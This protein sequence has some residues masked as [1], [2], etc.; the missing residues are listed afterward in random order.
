MTMVLAICAVVLAASIAARWWAESSEARHLELAGLLLRST[1]GDETPGGLSPHE[2]KLL[3]ERTRMVSSAVRLYRFLAFAGLAAPGW[4]LADAAARG[5]AGG[6]AP[7]GVAEA[8]AAIVLFLVLVA[9]GA[10]A[11]RRGRR[12]SRA[13]AEEPPSWLVREEAGVPGA[14]VA[15]WLVWDRMLRSVDA[16]LGPLG[17]VRPSAQLV[18][19]EDSLR[20]A[21]DPARRPE[22]PEADGGEAAPESEE[23]TAEDMV[24]A[25]QRLDRTLVR[26]IMRPVNQVTA[27]RLRDYTPRRFLALCART[28]Y[29]RIPCYE[30]HLLNLTGYINVFD[31]LH[32]DKPPKDLR[33]VV[34][35]ALYVPE[36][37]RVDAVLQ[38]MIAKRQQVA[39]VFDEF[40]GTSGWLSR[41]DILEEI[42]G[43]VE[44]E[45]ERSRQKLVP[46]RGG[47]LADP[48]I[49]LD[50]LEDELELELPRRHAD[51]L[52]G[53]IYYRLGR[54]PKR[55]EAIEEQG[56][57]IRVAAI[58]KHRIRRVRLIPPPEPS[59]GSSA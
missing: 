6:A 39:I 25:I 55:G 28:G 33:S 20:L 36:V 35:K 34:S 53:F 26:E 17:V 41:E 54:A 13:D 27:I 52:A 44:D 31:I 5:M 30:D 9:A 18:E 43:D 46:V 24:R 38:E 15:G 12:R 48:T 21:I 57:R 56:W 49:D 7:F 42:V 23:P 8:L 51:T 16:L 1:T 3:L 32:M 10:V 40:G 58:D 37:A 2:V 47:W 50:D 45:F 19:V 14:Y 4:I 29:T 11:A 59:G 22:A